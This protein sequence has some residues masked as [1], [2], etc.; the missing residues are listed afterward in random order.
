M[1]DRRS[2]FDPLLTISGWVV[3]SHA[4]IAV[5]LRSTALRCGDQRIYGFL[6]LRTEL[7]SVHE[8]TN[9][10]WVEVDACHALADIS[11]ALTSP[12]I[13]SEIPVQRPEFHSVEQLLLI[14]SADTPTGP[15]MGFR[16]QR[17]RATLEPRRVPLANGGAADLEF[18]GDTGLVGLV[19]CEEF[20]GVLAAFL[21]LRFGE[22]CGFPR[23]RVM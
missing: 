6:F 12:A 7:E 23:H 4:A 9:M 17:I 13:H 8:F 2:F 16:A 19:S 22:S 14:F 10:T 18:T 5:S 20:S 21:E 1:E 15:R 3:S 11:N